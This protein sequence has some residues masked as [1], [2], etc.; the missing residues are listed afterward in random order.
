VADDFRVAHNSGFLDTLGVELDRQLPVTQVH[1]DPPQGVEA[2]AP[3]ELIAQTCGQLQ[4]LA[5]TVE[6]LL[7]LAAVNIREGFG[8]E[9]KEKRIGDLIAVEI[10]KHTSELQS[11]QYLVCR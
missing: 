8:P 7:V 9:R 11:R 5:Q 1:V 2:A 3:K 4:M 10:G 6:S